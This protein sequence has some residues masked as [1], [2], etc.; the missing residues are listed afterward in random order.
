[1]WT[2]MLLL[3]LNILILLAI[4]DSGNIIFKEQGAKKNQDNETA[5]VDQKM[6]VAPLSAPE[7][8]LKKQEVNY[9]ISYTVRRI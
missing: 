5:T 6:Q 7:D 9:L 3:S 4:V 2:K 1:M 8:N